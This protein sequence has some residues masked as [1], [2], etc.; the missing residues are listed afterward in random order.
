MLTNDMLPN[1]MSDKMT[2]IPCGIVREPEAELI[3]LSRLPIGFEKKIIKAQCND[4]IRLPNQFNKRR[5]VKRLA[6]TAWVECVDSMPITDHSDYF[7]RL[8]QYAFNI[9]TTGG[10]IDPSPKAWVSMLVGS[11]PI[12]ERSSMYKA[13]A[14]LPV[15]FVEEW[16]EKAITADKLEI[17][18][19]SLRKYYEAEQLR[20]DVLY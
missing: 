16:N 1:M 4:R 10:G 3:A 8:R 11:I 20:K 18:L 6:E 19:D 13:Y 15:V 14:D 9:C 5:P 7:Q 17:W 12:I 2:P